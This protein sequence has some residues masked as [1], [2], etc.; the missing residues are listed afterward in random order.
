VNAPE[1]YQ[2]EVLP[3]E[4]APWAPH[5]TGYRF[6]WAWRVLNEDGS[7]HIRGASNGSVSEALESA[8]NSARRR[9]ANNH[10]V[11]IS[12]VAII[13]NPRPS[14]VADGDLK[15]NSVGVTDEGDDLSV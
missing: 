2:T 11:L 14:S 1:N 10:G 3:Y 8:E 12:K 9:I 13:K 15:S 5:L 6:R 7:V 4:E